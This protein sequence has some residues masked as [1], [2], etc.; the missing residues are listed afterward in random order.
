MSERSLEGLE[1]WLDMVA[2]L[3]NQGAH[4][5][6]VQQAGALWQRLMEEQRIVAL[7]DSNLKARDLSSLRAALAAAEALGISPTN[8][9]VKAGKALVQTLE[10]QV[11]LRGVLKAAVG[12]RDRAALEEAL[13][14]AEAMGVEG[15]EVEQAHTLMRRL[16]KEEAVACGLRQAMADRSLAAL[17]AWLHK[18]AEMGFEAKEV[19][20]A[21]RLQQQLQTELAA[22]SALA[23]AV[24]ERELRGLLA[25][26]ERAGK[27]GVPEEEK[28]V[29]EARALLATLEKEAEALRE[30][31]SASEARQLDRLEVAMAQAL[32]L[33]VAAAP[34]YV[35][36][37]G[38]KEALQAE[39]RC[40][41]N[42]LKAAGS[43][44]AGE[45]ACS[46]CI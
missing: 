1:Q 19:F 46:C 23:N 43:N 26:L 41:K 40:R 37:S 20:E 35:R 12:R 5:P 21:R 16:D 28:G 10:E 44:D 30:L 22:K 38:V 29:V 18:A 13:D 14:R 36:A 32:R 6:V 45:W 24:K 42:L 9:S 39:D 25:A 11:A 27:L 33:G 2:E 17:G 7:I 31:V 15:E 3:P 8:A 34:E 4:L